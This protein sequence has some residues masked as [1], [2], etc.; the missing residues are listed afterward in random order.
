[1]ADWRDR[2]ACRGLDPNMFF[3]ERGDYVAV[4][5][6]KA[7]CSSCPVAAECLQFAIEVGETE[8]IWG[9]KSGRQMKLY[10]RG[11]PRGPRPKEIEH[12]TVAGYRLHR[13]RG[14]E[15]CQACRDAYALHKQATRPSRAKRERASDAA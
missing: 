5:A 14:I 11:L 10:R 15:P 8:G 6:A 4:E 9:G 2:A 13:Y 1:M 7:V 12:G 3:P